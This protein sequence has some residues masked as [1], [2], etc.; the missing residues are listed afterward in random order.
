MM[1]TLPSASKKTWV[2]ASERQAALAEQGIK[3]GAIDVPVES[4]AAVDDVLDAAAAAW[5]AR[6]VLMGHAVSLPAGADPADPRRS[7]AIWY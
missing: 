5:S 3:L 2:G 4:R 7:P 6:R 1:G